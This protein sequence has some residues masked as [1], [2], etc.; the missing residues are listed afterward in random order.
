MLVAMTLLA[1]GFLV[2]GLLP[3]SRSGTPWRPSRPALEQRAAATWTGELIQQGREFR[4]NGY[5]RYFFRKGFVGLLLVLVVVTGWH[6]YLRLLPGAGGVLGMT[7]ALVIVLGLLDL[8]H[9][10]FGL[11]A[12]DDA[13]RVG[14]STQGL[15][16]WLLDWGKG[17]LIDWPMTALVV[18]V[19]FFLVAKW[20]RLW[21]LPAT[22]LAA[23][24]GI[25]L[26]L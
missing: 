5:G 3:W 17:I 12:W 10:P 14:L 22:G 6:R 15:G 19:L 11:A 23:V 26:T 24:G 16:G 18:A 13:R 9:L 20:P 2:L 8:L 21:P 25:V 4:S 7:A 1:A